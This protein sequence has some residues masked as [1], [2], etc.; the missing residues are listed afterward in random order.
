MTVLSGR[1]TGF[2]LSICLGRHGLAGALR[3]SPSTPTHS[4]LVKKL[5]LN[6]SFW[7]VTLMSVLAGCSKTEVTPAQPSPTATTHD[8]VITGYKVKGYIFL[9][10]PGP[11]VLGVALGHTAVGY[12]VRE[13]S[14]TTV[15]KVYTYCGAVENPSGAP[16]VVP[17]GFNGGW[18]KYDLNG[19]AAMMAHMRARNYTSYKFE[20]AF[21]DI[22]L[23][24][25]NGASNMIRYFPYRGYRVAENNCA[26]A[27]YDVLSWVRAPGLKIPYFNWKPVDQY[28]GMALN[29]GWSSSRAL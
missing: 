14:G 15:T 27:A 18:V 17:G 12:E 6:L 5:S 11:V 20:Q 29:S 13:M 24:D 9:R 22:A 28:N 4:N 25:L 16:V 19:N 10:M 8:A 2:R 23:S 7:L 3:Y 1:R 21:R 26:D